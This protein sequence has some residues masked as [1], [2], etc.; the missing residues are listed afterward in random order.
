[1]SKT[2]LWR[3]KM[4]K[5]KTYGPAKPTD[6]KEMLLAKLLQN[7]NSREL[8]WCRDKYFEDTN[9]SWTNHSDEAVACCAVGASML[10]EDSA[11]SR[12]DG[13]DLTLVVSGNDST[14]LYWLHSLEGG[15]DVGH[16]FKLAMTEVE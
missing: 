14:D 3:N 1:M 6:E 11:I 15:E 4:K 5:T 8:G 7:A 13:F 2:K 12:R 10:E 9:G 16:A